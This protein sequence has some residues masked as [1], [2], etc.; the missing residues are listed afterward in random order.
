MKPYYSQTFQFP[1]VEMDEPVPTDLMVLDV[2]LTPGKQTL[3][4]SRVYHDSRAVKCEEI[5]APFPTAINM[6][7]TV[8]AAK[9]TYDRLMR[10]REEAQHE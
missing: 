2:N 3:H 4:I 10:Q 5:I 1:V 7:H 9:D 8:S 6:F